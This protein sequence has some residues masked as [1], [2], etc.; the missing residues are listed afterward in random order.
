MAATSA[1]LRHLQQS[2]VIIDMRVIFL[3]SQ[4]HSK[5]A[6]TIQSKKRRNW[7]ANL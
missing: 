6:I 2:Q 1:T 4:H 7:Q 5:T 3:H